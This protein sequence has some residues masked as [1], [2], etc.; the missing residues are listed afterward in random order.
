MAKKTVLVNGVRMPLST[1]KQ[2]KVEEKKP[3]NKVAEVAVESAGS[4]EKAVLKKK[5]IKKKI[6]KKVAKK[7]E[8]AESEDL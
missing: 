5:S 1:V 7:V 2:E 4:D 6:S 3:V 8:V